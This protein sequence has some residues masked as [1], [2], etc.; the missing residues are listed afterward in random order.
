L[1][2]S[3]KDLGTRNFE[4]VTNEELERAALGDMLGVGET[5]HN[6]DETV[7]GPGSAGEVG[8]TGEGGDTVWRETLLPDEKN[9]LKKYFK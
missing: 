7:K 9:V 1:S 5:E 6:I 8:S 4:G 2:K 3:E